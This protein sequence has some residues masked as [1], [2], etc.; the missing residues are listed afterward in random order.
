[1][2][3]NDIQASRLEEHNN[4]IRSY[5]LNKQQAANQVNKLSSTST[6]S[7]KPS[8]TASSKQVK[9]LKS[10]YQKDALAS[11][12]KSFLDLDQRYA[13]TGSSIV[14][15]TGS[16]LGDKK[17]L[18]KLSIGAISVATTATS[19]SSD[20]VLNNTNN[21]HTNNSPPSEQNSSSQSYVSSNSNKYK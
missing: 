5:K 15:L 6:G 17:E 4:N 11:V 20:L 19:A 14:G 16:K 13:T 8:N 2:I 12:A 21:N 1:M 3:L 9:I 10:F 7:N 18:S